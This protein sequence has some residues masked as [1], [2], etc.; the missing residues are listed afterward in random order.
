MWQKIEQKITKLAQG[1]SL[2]ES[3]VVDNVPKLMLN[4]D[5]TRATHCICKISFL[6]FLCFWVFLLAKVVMKKVLSN[7]FVTY[8]N[9]KS[10]NFL[11]QDC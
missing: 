5:I 6:N 9:P 11:K 8:N 10:F 1:P 3:R 4:K 2:L 7:P